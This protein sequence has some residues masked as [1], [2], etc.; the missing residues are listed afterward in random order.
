MKISRKN[1]DLGK[2]GQQ[3]MLL[4]LKTKEYV[5]LFTGDINCHKSDIFE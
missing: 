5:V 3:Y 2:K 4:Y 1:P